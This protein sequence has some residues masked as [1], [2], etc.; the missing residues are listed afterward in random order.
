[1]SLSANLGAAR[2]VVD[3]AAEGETGLHLAETGDYAAIVLDLGLP[4]IDGLTV[5]E[6]F[7]SQGG[8]TPVLVLTARDRWRDR[9]LGL[10]A[11]ADDYLG[12]PFETEELIARL[13]AL[14]R[15][16]RRLA[17]SRIRVGDLEID[18]SSR[19]VTRS[20]TA[21]AL[22]PNEFRALT[23][24]AVNR[25]R[26]VS[27]TE[28]AEHVYDEDTDRAPNVVEV[29]IGRLRKKVGADMIATQRG[30]GYVIT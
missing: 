15:R 3:E 14:I 28:L 2:Y 21:I 1:T 16:A 24:L 13:E 26:V 27:K 9:V 23:F 30:H 5:L 20:G 22:S 11:G 25:G 10:R 17:Q 18:L 19:K 29:M 8:T 7:R 6:N 12:K 4:L